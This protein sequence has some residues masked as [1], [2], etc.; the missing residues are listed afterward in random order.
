MEII[1][2]LNNLPPDQQ[3]CALAI[4]NFDGVHL[5]HQALLRQLVNAASERHLTSVVM[6]FMPHPQE[7]FIP[8][9]HVA[10]LLHLREKFEYIA[11]T[12]VQ[13]LLCVRF[14]A[15]LAAMSA[16]SFVSDL[17]LERLGVHYLTVGDDFR[18]GH[19]R[20]GNFALLQQF[21]AQADFMVEAAPTIEWDSERVSSTRVRLALQQGDLV[22][23]QALLGRPYS[24]SGRVM[25]G[26]K[27]GRTIGFPTANINLKRRNVPVAGVYAVEVEGLED[28]PLAGVANIGSRP[29]IDGQ[30]SLLEVHLF[31][32]DRT[33]YGQRV[34]VILRHKIRD[35]QRFTGLDELKQQIALDAVQAKQFLKVNV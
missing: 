18:F 22:L 14:N 7:F 12:G 27:R 6:T 4:G 10:Y 29:T 35:E 3:G 33:I 23:A 19:Q 24:I 16:Q 28:R 17:L 25:H 13:R 20:Q 26:D 9:H 32:F 8:E 11:A 1:R 15:Q 30:R 34:N 2:G 21:A 31:D 5:G